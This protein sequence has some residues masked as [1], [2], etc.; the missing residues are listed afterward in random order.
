MFFKCNKNPYWYQTEPIRNNDWMDV[1]IIAIYI[2]E[3]FI[4][5][6]WILNKNKGS[7]TIQNPSDSKEVVTIFKDYGKKLSREAGLNN[8]RE[9]FV[10]GIEICPQVK[11]IRDVIRDELRRMYGKNYLDGKEYYIKPNQKHH[12][13]LII[14]PFGKC[15]IIN[16]CLV[17]EILE[18]PVGSK[19]N[20]SELDGLISLQRRRE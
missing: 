8:N 14:I 1:A 18:H 7:L 15:E 3:N 19:L 4:Q 9:H 10:V 13:D 12:F 17:E 11:I 5:S 16:K 20:I 2:L 6:N